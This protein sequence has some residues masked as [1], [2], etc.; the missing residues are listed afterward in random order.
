ML[1]P[2]I[3]SIHSLKASDQV[4]PK[5]IVQ[6]A[7]HDSCSKIFAAAINSNI[8]ALCKTWTTSESTFHNLTGPLSHR[9]V[10]KSI[11]SAKKKET[12]GRGHALTSVTAHQSPEKSLIHTDPL[13]ICPADIEATSKTCVPVWQHDHSCFHQG[14]GRNHAAVT[15][16]EGKSNETRRQARLETRSTFS[17]S[18]SP[19]CFERRSDQYSFSAAGYVCE[20]ISR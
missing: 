20:L 2:R 3:S 18:C 14:R 13:L 16:A 12:T 17:I 6:P 11:T 10:P 9:R 4:W 19:F 5:C 1:L 7:L 15:L 8:L